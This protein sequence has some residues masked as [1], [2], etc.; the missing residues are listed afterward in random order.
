MQ[1]PPSAVTSCLLGPNHPVLKRPQS[2]F[3]VGYVKSEAITRPVTSLQF[4]QLPQSVSVM[5][6]VFISTVT[7]FRAQFKLR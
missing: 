6:F 4:L 1:L 2:V 5:S 7:G 3:V